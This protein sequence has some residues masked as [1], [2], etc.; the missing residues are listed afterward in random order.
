MSYTIVKLDAFTPEESKLLQADAAEA[1]R[2]YDPDELVA[3]D[4][5]IRRKAGRPATVHA[6][7]TIQV[8]IDQESDLKLEQY[9]KVRHMKRSEAIRDLLNR[10]LA[11]VST[12]S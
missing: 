4:V 9:R 7:K 5:K 12:K 6:S 3:Q 1:E 11:E 10:A 8:R 2:G